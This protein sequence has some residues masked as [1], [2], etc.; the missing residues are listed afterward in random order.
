VTDLPTTGNIEAVTFLGSRLGMA[1]VASPELADAASIRARVLSDDNECA[2]ACARLSRWRPVE[3]DGVLLLLCPVAE[4]APL[5]RSGTV[6]I[7][8]GNRIGA[9]TP[10]DFGTD[11]L[12]VEQFAAGHLLPLDQST[13]AELFDELFELIATRESL[14]DAAANLS[15]LRELLRARYPAAEI[16]P[17]AELA[18]QID[19]IWRV[20]RHSVYVEGWLCDRRSRLERLLMVSPEGRSIEIADRLSRYRRPDVNEFLGLS[21]REETGFIVFVEL[22]EE[23]WLGTGWLLQ[24][25]SVDGLAFET[26]TPSVVED[27]LSTRTVIVDDIQLEGRQRRK[28]LTDHIAPAVERVQARLAEGVEIDFVDQHGT[29][30][31]SPTVSIIVPL[32]RQIEFLEL[33]LSQFVLD[34][35]LRDADLIYVLDSPEDAARLRPLAV[36]LFDLYGLPFRLATLTTNAGYSIVNNLGAT[37]ARSPKLLLMNSDVFPD[38]PGWLSRMV[39]FYDSDP[40]IGALAPKLLYEDGSIQHAGLYFDRIPGMKTWSNEHY[41]KGLHR[42]FPAAQLARA[43]PAVTGACLMIEAVLYRNLGGLR[44]LF[45]RGDYED[46]DLCLRLREE[47]LESWYLPDVELYHLEGQSYPSTEREA[48]SRFNQLM[49][50]D[51]WSESLPAIEGSQWAQ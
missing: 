3:A 4:G 24:G 36:H 40:K 1:V 5:P 17:Q 25:F 14:G 45:V 11:A 30:P 7:E 28:L 8:A 49:H 44:G 32:Y 23:S 20:D 15:V 48:A 46:S 35:E 27:P 41:Y 21:P 34:P 26:E 22:P 47:G 29:P 37:L 13:R 16:N 6:V 10:A 9:I 18:A 2:L 50:S 51:T 31:S 38:K 39:E 33:Q 12:A 43:V 42:G 19:G